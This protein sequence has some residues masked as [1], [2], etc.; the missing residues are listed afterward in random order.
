VRAGGGLS[1]HV[2]PVLLLLL[3]LRGGAA[4]CSVQLA[5]RVSLLCYSGFLSSCFLL[6][7]CVPGRLPFVFASLLAWG[8]GGKEREKAQGPAQENGTRHPTIIIKPL[9][10]THT[11]YYAIYSA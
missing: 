2:L 9:T 1:A 4:R 5:S 7:V 6:C 10:P 3:L 8:F 11:I